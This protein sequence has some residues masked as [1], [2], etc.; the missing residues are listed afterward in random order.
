[1]VVTMDFS[2]LRHTPAGMRMGIDLKKPWSMDLVH[3]S[4]VGLKHDVWRNL[5]VLL[6][7]CIV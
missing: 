7:I 6:L 5:M 2:R 3:V 1:M 4:L